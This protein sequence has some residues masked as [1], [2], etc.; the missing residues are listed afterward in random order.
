MP[1]YEIFRA[2]DRESLQTLP[3][4][5]PEDREVL[6]R[7]LW[8]APDVAIATASAVVR[9]HQPNLHE[10]LFARGRER[11]REPT[12]IGHL[13]RALVYLGLAMAAPAQGRILPTLTADHLSTAHAIAQ[14]RFDLWTHP[15]HAGADD[16]FMENAMPDPELR[17]VVETLVERTSA[18]TGRLPGGM[19]PIAFAEAGGLYAAL[20]EAVAEQFAGAVDLEAVSAQLQR[21]GRT[22][23]LLADALAADDVPRRFDPARQ[24]DYLER[25]RRFGWQEFRA[26]AG[27]TLREIAREAVASGFRAAT[28]FAL[29]DEWLTHGASQPTAGERYFIRPSLLP[30]SGGLA[31]WAQEERLKPLQKMLAG[32]PAETGLVLR[33]AS[34]ELLLEYVVRTQQHDFLDGR[35]TRTSNPFDGMQTRLGGFSGGA[36]GITLFPGARMDPSVGVCPII[37]V[38]TPA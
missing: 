5:R 38:T 25:L 32:D 27:R 20:V 23:D 13:A 22:R 6:E 7:L 4:L 8:L 30:D 24:R 11:P 3:R 1:D 15:A 2:A 10:L 35:W 19:R 12:A 29:T 17:A 34:V 16:W 26:S 9:T 18:R 36:Y 14:A 28:T 21:I 37:V 33:L 31:L